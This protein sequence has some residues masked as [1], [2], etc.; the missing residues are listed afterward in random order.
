[1][2]VAARGQFESLK[3]LCLINSSGFRPQNGVK[4]YWLNCSLY[5]M[6][7]LSP[8]TRFFMAPFVHFVTI[9]IIGLSPKVTQSDAVSLF[10]RGATMDFDHVKECAM[11]IH[12]SKVPV[13][14]AS[15]RDD[16]LVE[17]A[18]SDEI[19]QVL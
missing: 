7:V 18:I 3:G 2:K 10:H 15:A 14:Y 9:R 17:K 16:K 19:C 13:L 4:P 11:F 12:N 1:M 6:L 5:K 8:V